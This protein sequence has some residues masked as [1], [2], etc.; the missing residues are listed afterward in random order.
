MDIQTTLEGKKLDYNYKKY[1]CGE[2]S[3]LYRKQIRPERGFWK[4]LYKTRGQGYDL[5]KKQQACINLKV[6][7][8]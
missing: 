5:S 2:C 1:T 6:K 8:K 4:C 3:F 7:K